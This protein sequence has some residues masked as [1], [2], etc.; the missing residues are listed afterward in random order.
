[1][2][3]NDASGIVYGSV[4]QTG[5]VAGSINVVSE[6]PKAAAYLANPDNWPLVR[7]WDAVQAGV[8]RSRPGPGDDGVPP[9]VHRD[10][11][12]Q[13]S[14]RMEA[15]RDG[16]GMVYLVGSSAAGK[17]R[18]AYEAMLAT[19]PDFC[20]A[21]PVV[22]SD[23]PIVLEAVLR[24][25]VRCV[26]WLDDLERFLGPGEL[27]PV[28]LAACIRQRVPIVGTI[29]TPQ[30]ELFN[31]SSRNSVDSSLGQR[32]NIGARVLAM[33]D[34]I[35]LPRVWSPAELERAVAQND[36]RIAEAVECH[37]HYG[38]AE[39]LAAGPAIW[40]EWRRAFDVGG[41]PRGAALVSA[42]VD[43][44]R[45]G[46][47]GPYP[48]SL[49]VGL[50]ETYL[51]DQGGS[52]LRAEPLPEAFAWACET[53]LGVTSPL[54]P[55]Q[56]DRWSVFQYL[57]DRI[58]QLSTRPPVKD[59]VWQ[60]VEQYVTTDHDAMG[61]AIRAAEAATA[62]SL[63]VAEAIWR[64]RITHSS[65]DLAAIA[66]YNLGVLM[67]ETERPDEARALFLQSAEAGEPGAA[68][69]LS[70]LMGEDGEE[71]EARQWC[72]AAAEAGHPEA[73]FRLGFDL[74]QSG[75][76]EEA[77]SWYRRGAETGEHRCATNLGN[78]MSTTGRRDEAQ[79]WYSRA[80]EL[81]DFY[82][83]FNIGLFHH[84]SGRLELAVHWYELAYEQGSAEA[85]LNLGVLRNNAGDLV[86]AEKWYR[87]AAEKGLAGAAFNVG[88]LFA[89]AGA[90][91]EAEAWYRRAATDGHSPSMRMLSRLSY[92]AGRI[93]DAIA[94][95][96]QAVA[97]GDCDAA[98]ELAEILFELERY[99]EAIEPLTM[100]AE[101]GDRD[102]VFN[103]AAAFAHTGNTDQAQRWLRQAAEVGDIEAV[104]SLAQLLFQ[105]GRVAS[106]M[107]WVRRARVLRSREASTPAA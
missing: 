1:M 52:L 51:E 18:A 60:R 102:A 90:N 19:M 8:L 87:N 13:L 89:R 41:R 20:V 96:E 2:V 23:L 45:A 63:R 93:P 105:V 22:G 53:R 31:Q 82:A 106:A 34:P 62:V 88:N 27:D 30:F 77:E 91:E 10:V 98:M 104:T 56:E 73:C 100:A 83:A 99:D 14:S 37:R 16:G 74:E 9:Y 86:E 92:E 39:Y 75:L 70:V 44:E 42:A 36:E 26:L 76:I 58:E 103:L 69:N 46:L 48:R 28:M 95:L 32:A 43:L 68:F 11:D 17:T 21:A 78:I 25:G 57:V 64:S 15:V 12:D 29:R 101:R 3:G 54:L 47:P 49:L 40:S 72:R 35:M 67:L 24:S 4:V 71:A 94:Q 61:V 79:I 66:A 50:H 59:L 55:V 85:A 65:I 33:V 5:N 81:G 84:D 80:N 6:G 97:L 107:W 38:I 7:D